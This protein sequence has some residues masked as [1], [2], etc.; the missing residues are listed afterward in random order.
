MTHANLT[1]MPVVLKIKKI[2]DETPVIKTFY[3]DYSLNSRPGQFV[4]LWLPGVDEKPISISGDTGDEFALTIC[5]R[6]DTT[7]KM[8]EL[9]VGDQ[10]GV[11]GPYGT[12]FHFEQ[13]EN[14]ALVAGGYG[15]APLYYTAVEASKIGCK[16]DFI[17][18][19]HEKEN[20]VFL[21]RIEQVKNLTL[22]VATHDGSVGIKGR[23]TTI[24]EKLVNEKEIHRIMTCGPEMMMKT[25]AEIGDSKNI[26][27]QVSVERYMKCGFGICGQCVLDPM[28]I[29][30]CVSG[31]VMNS[32]VL[33]M[34]EDFGKYSRDDVGNKVYFNNPPKK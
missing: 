16:I 29:R 18:S 21:D 32:K 24:L 27:T 6:G 15:A 14:I 9:K 17:I 31:P 2:K 5:S 30:S 33:K 13:D 10:L 25:A 4:M 26:N 34:L 3:F 12:S 1:E 22:H 7:K 28:G 8:A 19:A 20:L 11:R 23:G